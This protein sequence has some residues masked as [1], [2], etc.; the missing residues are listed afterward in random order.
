MIIRC[1]VSDIRGDTARVSA[2]PRFSMIS[3]TSTYMHA[4]QGGSSKLY[5]YEILD[6][7]YDTSMAEATQHDYDQ[8]APCCSS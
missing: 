2:K 8:A 7:M 3:L 5:Q 4:T 1:R 6:A